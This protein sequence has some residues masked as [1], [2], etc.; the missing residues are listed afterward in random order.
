MKRFIFLLSILLSSFSFAQIDVT[1]RVDMQYQQVS[2]NGV[3]IAGSMQGWNPSS[4]TLSDNDGDGIWEVTLTLSENSSYEYKFIN[5]ASWGYDESVFGGCGAGNGNRLLLTS[6]QS[7]ILPAYVFNSCDFTA[8]GCTD[9]NALNYDSS[10]NNDDGSCEYPI[11]DG[12]TDDTACNYNPESTV[13][14]GSCTYANIGYDCDENCIEPNIEWIGDQNNDGFVNIDP[15]SGD[16]YITIESYPNT[17]S[18]TV[19]IN[20]NDYP[21]N[22]SDWGVNAHWYYAI[23]AENDSIYNWSVTISNNCN[24]SQNYSDVFT[25]GCN[26]ELF[27]TCISRACDEVPTDLFVDNIIDNRVTFNWSFS[28]VSPSDYA[29]RYRAIGDSNW[30]VITMEGVTSDSLPNSQTNR[31]RWWMSAATTYEWSVRSRVLNGDNSINCQS[32]WSASAEYTTLPQCAN[33]ENLAV[34]NVEANWVTFLADAPDASW[35]VWQSK[36]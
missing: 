30:T 26:G 31:T 34:D 24:N 20:G 2:A 33:L 17:G 21:M 36:G 7:M 18:G 11:V 22:Y 4:T 6:D 23:S 19:N 15:N 9:E 29:I 32:P 28:A 25:T 12:C 8:Y 5:G 1:F 35:G 13:D 14:D 3:H 10:A 27:D 16:V